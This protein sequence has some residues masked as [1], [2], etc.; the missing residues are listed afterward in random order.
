ML[1]SEYINDVG[2]C[3]DESHQ[4]DRGAHAH[5]NANAHATMATMRAIGEIQHE[6]NNATYYAGVET[7]GTRES[8]GVYQY[9]TF[10]DP[11]TGKIMVGKPHS[12][13]YCKQDRELQLEIQPFPFTNA[14]HRCKLGEDTSEV[15]ELDMQTDTIEI[16]ASALRR[17]ILTNVA[18]VPP[19]ITEAKIAEFVRNAPL[20]YSDQ[21]LGVCCDD[22]ELHEE[23]GDDEEDDGFLED[24]A[25]T[26]HIFFFRSMR[27]AGHG[28]RKK[29]ILAMPPK[30]VDGWMSFCAQKFTADKPYWEHEFASFVLENY[31]RPLFLQLDPDQDVEKT[32]YAIETRAYEFNE[33]TSKSSLTAEDEDEDEDEPGEDRVRKK[34][35]GTIRWFPKSPKKALC[36]AQVSSLDTVETFLGELIELKDKHAD[37]TEV[38]QLCAVLA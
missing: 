21:D 10:E 23:D 1:S 20:E 22:E 14:Q 17:R 36:N 38:F 2:R 7:I 28:R 29:R 15:I 24:D 35:G 3:D 16:P 34:R 27:V 26:P 13:W 32:F 8:F 12:F 18:Y 11:T 9:A 19:N 5:A 31:L 6:E 4:S 30:F 37:H 33:S 25:T